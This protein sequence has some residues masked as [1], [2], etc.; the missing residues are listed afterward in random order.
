M[1]HADGQY[2]PECIEA[3]LA[4]LARGEADLVFG[5][6]LAGAPLAG[7][8][9]LH[10]FVGNK[11]LTGLANL[12]LDWHLSEFH[13][14]YRAYRCAAL[15]TLPLARLADDYEF[16]VEILILFRERGLRVEE[17]PIPTHYGEEQSHINVWRTGVAIL[18]VLSEYALHRWG[19]RHS[20]KFDLA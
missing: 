7:H 4:P 1:L 5:S 12:L 15:R 17:M 11:A 8:M 6:R 3:L 10:R 9:P 16:D 19:L 20:P 13:S 2:A 14:G 18:G